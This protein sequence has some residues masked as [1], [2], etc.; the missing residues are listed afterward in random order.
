[1][2]LRRDRLPPIASGSGFRYDEFWRVWLRPLHRPARCLRLVVRFPKEIMSDE[3]FDVLI[4]GA[5][6]SGIAAGYYLQERCASRRY[7][8]VEGRADL[9]GTWGL[10]RYPGVRADSDMFTLGYSFKPW[11]G[12]RA[13]ALGPAILNYLRETAREFGIDGRIRFQQRVHSASWSSGRARWTVI[14]EVGESRQRVQYTCEFLLLCSGYYNYEQG[15][16]PTFAGRDDFQGPV[17]HPQHWP[18]DLDYRGRRIVVIGSGATAVTLVPALAETAAHVTMLQRSPSYILSVPAEDG[19][20]RV[21]RRCLPAWAGHRLI[22]WKNVL[23][24]L[25]FYQLCRR[26]PDLAKRLLRRGLAKQ[27]PPDFDLDKHFT[28]RYEPWDQR[29]CFVPDGDLFQ[30]L[31]AGRA[32]VVT[33]E[34]ERL[35]RHGIMLKSGKELPA[36]VIVTATGLNLLA[37]GG[38]CLDV[39]GSVV[40][41]GRTFIYKGVMLSNVPNCAVCAGYA[42]ASWTLR[43]ELSAE[44]VCRLLNYMKRHGFAQCVPR[45]DPDTAPARPL[46]PLTS[47]YVRRGSDTFL[48]QG[49][50]AP[51]VMHQNYLLDL[52]SVRLAKWNDGVLE[53]AKAG[54]PAPPG[55]SQPH[56][57]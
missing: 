40:E 7:V 15:H 34:V 37:G 29:L 47:G 32:S 12:A 57:P 18:K 45:C 8:I 11:K 38:I 14:A 30:T 22:R 28:P 5:G 27:L 51:W 31:R 25:Y 20:A 43:A 48:K 17:V 52:F 41:A 1:V 39:D 55:R 36:D 46:L 49:S 6:L 24:T 23:L 13:I 54:A 50:K 4:V 3:H 44:Y 56:G 10:F 16:L 42:N 21:I 26:K 35:T 9:G 33:D 53:F 2:R 19:L